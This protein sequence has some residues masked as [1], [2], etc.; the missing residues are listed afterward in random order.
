MI[1]LDLLSDPAQQE[2]ESLYV[3]CCFQLV[4][5]TLSYVDWNRLV[6]WLGVHNYVLPNDRVLYRPLLA[7]L[8]D[9][10]YPDLYALAMVKSH[11][12]SH[13]TMEQQIKLCHGKELENRPVRAERKHAIMDGFPEQFSLEEDYAN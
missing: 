9:W 1:D 11:I 5:G 13:L 4:V 3:W 6:R 2:K 8:F 10:H 7:R 12:E